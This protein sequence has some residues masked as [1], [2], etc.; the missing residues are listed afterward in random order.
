MDRKVG[1][2]LWFVLWSF[3]ATGLYMLVGLFFIPSLPSSNSYWILPFFLAAIIMTL[4]EVYPRDGLGR[5]AAGF[6]IVLTC[7]YGATGPLPFSEYPRIHLVVSYGI[8]IFFVVV[9]L[10]FS[11]GG[12]FLT[13]TGTILTIKW[14]LLSSWVMWLG[15]SINH[16]IMGGSNF[17]F[18]VDSLIVGFFSI[19]A[20][21]VLM[22]LS[23]ILRR[24]VAIFITIFIWLYRRGFARTPS[25]INAKN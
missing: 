8:V 10:F 13:T 6:L 3:A 1:Q 23:L 20:G 7:L 9:V 15:L 12:Y 22:F 21:F 25:S 2:F 18:F 24:F 4:K 5:L 17:E 19:L 16:I 11:G 14:V